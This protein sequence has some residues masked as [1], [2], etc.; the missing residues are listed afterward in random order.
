MAIERELK[1]R[2]SGA[3][4]ARVARV[5]RLGPAQALASVYFD[6]PDE[7]LRAA[8]MALRLRRAGRAW[9]QTLKCEFAPAARGEWEVPVARKTLE[10]ARLPLAEIQQSTGVDLA[11]LGA[12]L[13]PRFETR[14]TR[15]VAELQFG[16][17]RIEAALDRGHIVA[18]ARRAPIL[19][20]ELELK[21]GAPRELARYAKTLIDPLQ[22]RLA[23]ESKAERGYRLAH[24][25]RLALPQKWRAPG[26]AAST[27]P[28]DA[29]AALAAA[30]LVQAGANAEGLFASDDPEYLHQLR[31]GLRRLRAVLGA[32][33]ALAPRAKPL[34]RRLRA[35]APVLGT[36]RDWDVFVLAVPAPASV[37]P[38][39][40]ARQREARRA[41]SAAVASSA[42]NAFL[43]RAL[44]WIED[45]PWQA[46]PGPLAPFAA[47]ALE[48]LHRSTIE[49][50]RR[51]DWQDATERHALRIRVKRLRYAG[52]AFGVCYDEAAR[53]AYLGALEQ[54]QDD[55]GE[56]NDIAVGRRLLAE[57]GG[58]A[59]IERRFAGRERRL[60]ARLPGDWRAFAVRAPFWR[61]GS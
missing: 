43:V 12:R 20:L 40:R 13:G 51:I 48:R 49:R 10:L 7:R 28:G 5:L 31:V 41:A 39:A 45:R 55:F 32:F 33:K 61:D 36:A 1:F 44:Q 6:S 22:L 18:G 27:A 35:L 53:L 29:L 14:F 16:A 60:I 25:E 52:D 47:Q 17:A 56:L 3:A 58:D 4:A 38:R 9:L 19:E 15:R 11:A 8:R 21:S 26:L 30:A 24:G 2:L 23:L 59:G 42:F 54:L 37:L 34:K 57:L 50:G 46:V